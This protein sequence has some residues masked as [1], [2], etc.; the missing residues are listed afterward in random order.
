MSSSGTYIGDYSKRAV[1]LAALN[2]KYCQN[3]SIILVWFASKTNLVI[4][5]LKVS[6][7]FLINKQR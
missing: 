2:V 4:Q 1:K 3:Q 5:K 6:L 7:V